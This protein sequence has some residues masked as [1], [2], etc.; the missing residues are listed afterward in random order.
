MTYE[1]AKEW[2][3]G[4]QMF[5]IKLG[6]EHPHQLLAA[7]D[8]PEKQLRFLHVAGTNGKGSIC[9]FA[10]CILREAGLQTGLFTS[11]HLMDFRERMT[12]NG[13]MI[14]PQEMIEGVERLHEITEMWDSPP[15]FFELTFALALD[16]FARCQAEIVVLETGMGGRLDATNVVHPIV[17]VIAP[18]SLDHGQWLGGSLEDIAKE[19]AGIIKRGVPL[20]L[21]PQPEG[22]RQVILRRAEELGAPV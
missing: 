22:V 13:A 5:G 11:P 21:L 3:F 8:Q 15:T 9:S 7:L 14:S 1:S 12:L 20:I 17:T 16:W 6:L 19:K 18:I 4:A 2:L 10:A